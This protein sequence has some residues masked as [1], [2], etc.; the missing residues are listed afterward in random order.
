[1]NTLVDFRQFEPRSR[2]A[3]FFSIYDSLIEGSHFDFI[4]DHDPQ[5]LYQQIKA[6]NLK[7]L[8]WDYVKQGPDVWQITVGKN[9]TSQNKTG[10]GCCGLCGG[11]ET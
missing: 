10:E 4:N 5:T 2:H 9:K 8:S 7:G 1:M 11:H 6:L 3:I